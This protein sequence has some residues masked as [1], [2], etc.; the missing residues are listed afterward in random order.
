MQAEVLEMMR[1]RSP[2]ESLGAA[3]T[4]L[5]AL[6]SLLVLAHAAAPARAAEAL[7]TVDI[8]AG[9]FK[10]VRLRNLPKGAVMAVGIESS[11]KL[12]VLLLNQQDAKR[13]PRPEEPIFAGSADRRLSFSVVI[14]AAGHYY[15]VLDNRQGVDAQKLKLAI[16]AE[17]GG[18]RQPQ[19]P[20]PL[21]PPA[22]EQ[23]GLDKL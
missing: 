20:G 10:A 14:P 21:P 9:R 17:R 3:L 15:L 23:K 22:G 11:G 18:A 7:L 13:F 1:P 8:P 16:R 19:T 2:R 6:L 12:L 4:R 5:T